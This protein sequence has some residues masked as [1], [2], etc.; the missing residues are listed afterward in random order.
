MNRFFMNKIWIFSKTAKFDN[1]SRKK[2]SEQ[3]DWS[4]KHVSLGQ[5]QPI[6]FF[7]SVIL[8]T[9]SNLK[10]QSFQML[11][12]HQRILTFDSFQKILHHFAKRCLV[13]L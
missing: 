1:N 5:V 10:S 11:S 6:F 13:T 8:R 4:V 12:F 7:E 3:I 9:K 2:S